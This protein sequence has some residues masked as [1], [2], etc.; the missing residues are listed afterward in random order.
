MMTTCY[1]ATYHE[2]VDVA[3]ALEEKFRIHKESKK[4]KQVFPT[5]QAALRSAKRLSTTL[6]TISALCTIRHNIKP[7][8]RRLSVLPQPS[9]IH[10]SRMPRVFEIRARKPI[11]FPAITVESQATSQRTARIQ[12]NTTL[13]TQEPPHCN[14]STK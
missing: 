11:T 9:N 13:I 12:G 1:N 2:V 3:I 5:H 10:N 8:S 7:D 6:R 14:N 4:K